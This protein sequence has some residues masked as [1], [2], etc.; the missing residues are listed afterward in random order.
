MELK[1]FLLGV[2]VALGLSAT[3]ISGI[4]STR[5]ASANADALNAAEFIRNTDPV[6]KQ[7]V[8]QLNQ[9]AKQVVSLR[10]FMAAYANRDNREV[11]NQIVSEA[12]KQA[13]NAENEGQ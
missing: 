11:F 13:Q 6:I 3:V 5:I 7:V 12:Q 8:S 10:D 9:N 4:N 1:D 2:A